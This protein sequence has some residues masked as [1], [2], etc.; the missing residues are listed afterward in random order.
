MVNNSHHLKYDQKPVEPPPP[1]RVEKKEPQVD[2]YQKK[3][4]EQ[5]QIRR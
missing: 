2:M 5:K 1:L 4:Y 3:E